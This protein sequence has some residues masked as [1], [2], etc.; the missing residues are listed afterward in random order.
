MHPVH[1]RCHNQQ[2]QITINLLWKANIAMVEHGYAIAGTVAKNE[3]TNTANNVFF[4]IFFSVVRNVVWGSWGCWFLSS[5]VCKLK[6]QVK[7]VTT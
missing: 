2:P 6:Q 7:W 1:V 3:I 5:F 4:M